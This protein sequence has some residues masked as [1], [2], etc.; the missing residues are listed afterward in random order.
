VSVNQDE[1]QA[2][3]LGGPKAT[4]GPI[5]AA[6]GTI[7]RREAA[8]L[9]QIAGVVGEDYDLGPVVRVERIFGGYCNAS[10][11]VWTRR[12][13]GEHTYFVRKYNPAIRER[14]VRFEHALLTYVDA[15][16]FGLASHVFPTRD[17]STFV[18]RDEVIDGADTTF[19]FAVFTMLE[20][21]DKYT[22]IQNRVTDREFDSGARVLARF[23]HAADGFDPGDLAR[24]QPPIMEFVPM[25][26]ESWPALVADGGDTAVD[27]YL[28]ERLPRI[29]DVVA[30]GTEVK[31]RLV[32]MPVTP[33]HCDYHPG[34]LK[35][36]DETGVGLFD[37]DWAKLDYRLFD[38]AQGICYF[39]MSW[40]G[41]DRGQLRL[42]K[43]EIFLRAYQDEA[44]RWAIPGRISAAELAV[45]PRMIAD[46]NLY[47]LNWDVTYFYGSPDSDVDEYMGYVTG[48]VE[49]ME[50]I[51]GH[52]DEL[53]HMADSC[54]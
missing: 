42:D 37:F 36:V 22:W 54:A 10:F 30:R 13:D 8:L 39:C 32:G 38:V 48:Q 6:E 15:A 45:L 7:D 3:G 41:A 5:G 24:E 1:W 11:G 9:S 12:D 23:H 50:F 49:C 21:E 43:A 20:G 47:I 34:N 35:W 27:R 33:T 40:E 4:C 29:L 28:R 25:W 52:L 2:G 14:E 44:S 53:A 51:E 46:A 16:G 26:A 31:D 18:T 19:Y 17:G